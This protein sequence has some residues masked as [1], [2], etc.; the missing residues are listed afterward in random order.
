TGVVPLLSP[1]ERY[2][3]ARELCSQEQAHLKGANMMKTD[4]PTVPAWRRLRARAAVL[5]VA[6]LVGLMGL[7]A[8]ACA[9]S[10]SPGS[11]A[12]AARTITGTWQGTLHDDGGDRR[13][14]MKVS[15]RPN[16][17][18]KAVLYDVD[19]DTGVL[20]VK[21]V[22]VKGTTITWSLAA[23]PFSYEGELSADG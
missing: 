1:A 19:N 23:P 11:G 20:P 5:A 12:G 7:F 6:G 17:S 8:S 9:S 14:V 18:W 22:T 4:T 2:A 21:S 10:D 13:I 15:K 3:S 16:G